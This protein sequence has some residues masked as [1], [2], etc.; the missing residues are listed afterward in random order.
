MTPHET[1]PEHATEAAGWK[2]K[3][4]HDRSQYADWGWIRD[5]AGELVIIVKIPFMEEEGLHEHR[6]NGTDP[7]QARVDLILAAINGAG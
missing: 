1:T 7:A 3:L 5:E 2:G 6:R 4:T